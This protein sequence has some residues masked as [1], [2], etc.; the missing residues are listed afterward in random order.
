MKN[1]KSTLY[2]REMLRQLL[3]VGS[4]SL[5][6]CLL[7]AMHKTPLDTHLEDLRSSMLS[8]NPAISEEVL[9]EYLTPQKVITRRVSGADYH[10]CFLNAA[11]HRITLTADKGHTKTIIG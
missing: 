3:W 4:G 5:L 1:T 10:F 2:R 7:P 11:G 8:N 6:P 9:G